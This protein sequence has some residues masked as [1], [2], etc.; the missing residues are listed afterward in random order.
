MQSSADL[1][2]DAW[3]SL[4]KLLPL[5]LLETK[6]EEAM[7]D[8]GRVNILIAGKTG[9]GKTT[10]VNAVFGAKVGET[11]V[12]GP[13]TQEIIWHEPPGLPIRLC[14]T[15]GLEVAAFEETLAAIEQEIKRAAS[16]GRIE[17]RLHLAWLCIA[18]P[19][20]RIEEAEQRLAQLCH[21]HGIPVIVVITKAFGSTE[22]VDA[23]ERLIPEAKAVIPVMAEALIR[24]PFPA[25]GLM[26]LVAATERL[27]PQAVENAFVAA[28]Q[29]DLSAKRTRAITVARAAA[30][31]AATAALAP[32]PGVGTAAVLAINAGMIAGIAAA[33]GVALNRAALLPLG[34]SLAGG[35]AA[36]AGGRMLLAESLKFVPGVGWVIG[37]AIE[38]SI[39]AAMTYGLGIGFTEFLLWFHGRNARMPE[40]LELR[41]GF[42]RFWSQRKTKEITPPST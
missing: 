3:E 9:S 19:S 4:K 16:S 5:E 38:S 2:A 18:E 8:L 40:G 12:G 14:D 20:A 31:A 34:A 15:R 22:F 41:D 17:D 29:V 32:I 24:P 6:V 11:G 1:F 36:S 21:Q 13:V 25:H 30:A 42:E 26:E 27:L 23:A 28:Q 35:L 7:R 33:M 37:A 10:L 39:A